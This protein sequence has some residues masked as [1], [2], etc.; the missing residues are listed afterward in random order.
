MTSELSFDRLEGKEKGIAV[1]VTEDGTSINVPRPLLP[2]AAKP[3]D[4]LRLT[5]EVDP[6]ATQKLAGDTRRLQEELK[7]TDPGGDIKL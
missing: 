2:A 7:Q 4:V 1:L 5:L 3:G 6:E